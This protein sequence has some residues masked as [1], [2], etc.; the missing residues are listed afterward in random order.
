MNL[1]L[2]PDLPIDD[3]EIHPW[4]SL[5]DTYLS[6]GETFL[7]IAAGNNGNSN[8]S[9][10]LDRVQ[11]PSDC[12]NALSVGAIDQVDSGWKRA[13]YSAVGP[14]RSP[15]LVKPD[16]VTFGGTPKQ[17][18]H[19]P[20]SIDF[21]KL[22]PI[23]GT[24]FSAPY[25]L[26]YAV[27]IRA[28]LG[29]E[30]STLAIK[31]LLINS[32]DQSTHEKT[33][34]GWGKIPNS[35]SQIVESPDGT[36]KILY[37]GELYPGKYLR[38]PLPIPK[39]GITGKVKI[40]ATCCFSSPVD[41]QDTSMYTKAGI[42]I[43]WRPTPDKTDTFFKQKT[44]AT[45]AELRSDAG[46]WESVLHEEKGKLGSS[47][48]DPCFEI[49]YMARD[50]GDQIS[51]SKAAIIKYAFIVSLEAPKTPDIFNDILKSNTKLIEIQPRLPIPIPISI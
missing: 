46:K 3:D 27:G 6:D 34:V 26:R 1:S 49:H 15:G 16:L 17:Y 9:L 41:P 51:G 25:L 12:V 14:G 45:E 37:Q 20:S 18:F 19:I 10:G 21:G 36:A 47:L 50:G 23:C 30:I 8:N 31:A 35:I 5:I 48:N 4:T 32:A 24:S 38:V 42:E 7:T 40:K 33:E 29:Y 11:V 39:N 2:G 22:T 13:S 43:T 28:I 44:V